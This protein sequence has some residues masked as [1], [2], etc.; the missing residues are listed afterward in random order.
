MSANATK[1]G[2]LDAMKQLR[3]RWSTIKMHW[4]DE[5]ALRFEKE[6][7]DPL[8]PAILAAVRGVEHVGELMAQVRRECGD[9]T[10]E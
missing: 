4:Q 7:I 9:D 3:L 6:V 8:E 2:L 1:A 5:A 10:S